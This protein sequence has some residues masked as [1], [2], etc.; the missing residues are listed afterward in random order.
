MTGEAVLPVTARDVQGSVSTCRRVTERREGVV[1]CCVTRGRQTSALPGATNN[2]SAVYHALEARE[3]VLP[4]EEPSSNMAAAPATVQA[5]GACAAFLALATKPPT[6]TS[7]L[8]SAVDADLLFAQ[9]GVPGY[10]AATAGNEGQRCRTTDRQGSWRLPDAAACT[11]ACARCPQCRYVSW[12]WHLLDCS[13]F[14]HCETARLHEVDNTGHRTL[15]RTM[16]NASGAPPT[17]GPLEARVMRDHGLQVLPRGGQLAAWHRVLHRLASGRKVRVIVLGGSMAAGNDCWDGGAATATPA[18]CSWSGRFVAWL[19]RR[20]GA[21]AVRCENLAIGGT[22]TAAILPM[23]PELLRTKAAH[24]V[25]VD[26]TVNDLYMQR[27]LVDT[28]RA[29]PHLG[30][31][32]LG[33]LGRPVE[34]PCCLLVDVCDYVHAAGGR[35]PTTPPSSAASAS[36]MRGPPPRASPAPHGR[37]SG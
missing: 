37:P 33:R 24:L 34:A 32:T 30:R 9:S 26:F 35:T 10:C 8:A 28:T 17:R 16:W 2:K 12:S 31:T 20:F 1:P 18:V 7:R 5:S 29:R 11:D 3:L 36:P 27:R 21:D 4:G 13:W 19:Q 15:R 14:A 23:L 6:Q 25:L 22:T